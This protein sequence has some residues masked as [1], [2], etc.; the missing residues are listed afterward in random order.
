MAAYLKP[1]AYIVCGRFKVDFEAPPVS[2]VFCVDEDVD[3]EQNKRQKMLEDVFDAFDID[4]SGFI[5]TRELLELGIARRV[6]K[7]KE[8]EWT[9][10]RNE[11]LIQ[12]MDANMDGVVSKAEFVKGFQASIE[13]TDAEV[14]KRIREFMEV[15]EFVRDIDF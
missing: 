14:D 3:M 6:L 15:A 13:G 2:S 10:E 7:Q 8:Q 9:V 12:R 1:R 11:K 5:E 4:G